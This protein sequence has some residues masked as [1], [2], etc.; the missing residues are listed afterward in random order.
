MSKTIIEMAMYIFDWLLDFVVL[1]L[2]GHTVKQA[3]VTFCSF[4]IIDNFKTFH[5]QE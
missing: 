4:L 5:V 1:P 3:E 2:P